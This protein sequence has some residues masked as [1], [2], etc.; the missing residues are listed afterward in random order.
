M[1]YALVNGHR[2]EAEPGL[3]GECPDFGSTLVPKCG[4]RRVWHWAHRGVRHCDHW[5]ES[6]TEWHRAWKNKFPAEWREIVHQAKD[7][8]KHI[9]DVKTMHG[10]VI[11][12]QHSYLKPEERRARETF[13]G[14]MVWVVDALRR[15]R[16]MQ[17]FFETLYVRQIAALRPLTF[18]VP[19]TSCALL[20][21]WAGSRVAVF[22]D[23]GAQ[24]V[25]GFGLPILW[26]LSPKKPE[27]RALLIPIPVV[28]FLE[29]L[30]NGA[31][32]KGIR[33]VESA[34]SFPAPA[35]D[36]PQHRRKCRLPSFQQYMARKHRARS[37]RRM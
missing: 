31:P 17:S 29:A 24:Q 18:S 30:R 1:R 10:R 14:S 9:A 4:E 28:N 13:Y 37:R 27:G 35:A 26:R 33:M 36:W 32:L 34:V 6:E 22:F 2:R 5:W 12:F 3:S 21:D 25:F 20:R 23:F 19:S 15:K 8:E 16:D 7:G 11:E